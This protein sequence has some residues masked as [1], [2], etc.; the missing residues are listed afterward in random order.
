MQIPTRFEIKTLMD[1]YHDP[2]LSLFLPVERVGPETQQNTVRLRNQLREVEKQIEGNPDLASKK[3]ELLQPLLKLPDNEEFWLEEGWGLALFRNLEQ[4]R[5]YRLPQP[6][7]EQFV[8]AAHFYLKPLLPFLTDDDR[9]YLLA[10][11]Q[12]KI[13]LLEGT[14]S[15]IHEMILPER[16]PE[17]LAAALRYDEPE[18]EEL[19]Y[20]SSSSGAMTGKGGRPGIIFHG[21]GASDEAKEHLVRYFQQI[22]RGLHELLHDETAPLVLAGVE[23]L[24]AF[25]RQVNTYPHLLKDGLAGNPDDETARVLHERVWPLIEPVLSRE[26][27]DARARYEEYATTERASN[28]LS[29]VVPAAY[30]GRVASLFVAREEEQ[31]GSFDP[32]NGSIEI[33]DSARAGDDDLLERAATQTILHGGAVYVQDRA[34]IP[35]GQAVAAVFRYA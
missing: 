20:H 15:T 3:E 14:R 27:Q 4:F 34:G 5:V 1:E 29:L 2:C 8:I 13:R 10:L 33:H 6:V 19:Q 28:N 7:K 30:A 35:G 24:Q 22:N 25:Y 12:N 16:V 21:M 23:Y 26:Q 18:K 11:S 31:W 17:S 9:F 32:A